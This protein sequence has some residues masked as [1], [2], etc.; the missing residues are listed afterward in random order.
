MNLG[1]HLVAV[2][3]EQ[4]N[5]LLGCLVGAQQAETIVVARTVDACGH[6]VVQGADNLCAS[7]LQQTLGACAGVDV[8]G[9]NIPRVLQNGTRVV[10]EDDLSLSAGR[11]DELL[12]VVNVVNAGEYVGLVAEQL[13]VLLLGQDIGPG[14]YTLSSISSRS[15]RWLPTS[16]EG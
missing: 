2:D 3:R 8:A 1:N 11:L 10:C 16:S 14:V 4:L 5:G 9:Q 6:N 12:V 15:I 7:L 13:A